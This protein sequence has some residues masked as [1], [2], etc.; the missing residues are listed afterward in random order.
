MLRGADGRRVFRPG[1]VLGREWGDSA[2]QGGIGRNRPPQSPPPQC[3]YTPGG[4]APGAQ[5][6]GGREGA[7]MSGREPAQYVTSRRIGE[8]TVTLIDD[9]LL[10]WNPQLPITEAVRQRVMPE[11]EADGTLSLGLHVA[12]IQLGAASILVD[13][14]Y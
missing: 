1:R 10:R 3:C 7:T 13:T 9:G 11:A 4:C 2:G 6:G 8:A 12:H 5:R 14:G